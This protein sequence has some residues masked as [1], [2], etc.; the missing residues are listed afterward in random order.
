[1]SYYFFVYSGQLRKRMEFLKKFSNLKLALFGA[2]IIMSIIFLVAASYIMV[3]PAMSVLYS[4]LSPEDMSVVISRLEAMNISHETGNNG[5]D[6]LVPMTKVTNLRMTFAQEGIPE[7][8]NLVGYEI[9]DKTDALGTSQFVYNVNLVRALEG[10]LARTIGTLSIV[11]NAR[12]HIVLPKKE[13]FSKVGNEPTASVVLRLRSGQ[14][15][16]KQEIAGISHI[17]ATAVPSLKVENITIIDHRGRPLKLSSSEDNNVAA[18]TDNASDF[19]RQVE[20]K[21]RTTLEELLEKSVGLGKVKTNVSAEINF[22]REV[23]NTEL[24]DPEGSV[25]R[26][27]KVS[28]ETDNE[29]DAGSSELSVTSN[30][31]GAD[32]AGGG[33]SRNKTRTDEVTNFEISKTVTNKIIESGRIK[34]LSIAVLVDGTYKPKLAADGITVEGYDY[35][36][37]TAEEM[38]KIKTLAVSAVGLDTKRGDIL[39]VINLQFSED[40]A[41]MPQKEK[42]MSWLKDQLDNVVQTVVIGIVVILLIL[43]VVRPLILRSLDMKKVSAEEEELKDALSSMQIDAAGASITRSSSSGEPE[44]E[45]GTP[46]EKRG[47]NLLKL[48]NDLAEKHPEE[49][50]A[51]IRLWINVSEK[52]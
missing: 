4:N 28:E 37:R 51:I 6:I 25:V 10:E 47:Q 15:L 42:A 12:V 39:E 44:I 1:M 50:V 40:F 9:F 38:D 27:K 7:S 23:I 34:K 43:L 46:E 11:D 16:S 49:T 36:Q 30:L 14:S 2:G 21:L 17:I 48:V 29:R 52:N 35:I 31:E 24:F 26:S 41:T 33:A 5:K 8:G 32:G 22:D 3:K 13:L 19:Q 45:T 20:E 18:I